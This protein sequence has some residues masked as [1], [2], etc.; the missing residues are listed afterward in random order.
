MQN[1]KLTFLMRNDL[2]EK[3]RQEIIQS[4]KEKVGEQ[5]S[6]TKEDLWGVRDLAYTIKREKK[7]YYVYLEFQAKPEIIPSLDKMMKLNED[8]LRYL[9]T[10]K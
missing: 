7:A 4:V 3:K 5:S 9:I 10:R 8:I 6:I 1:Y 2:D